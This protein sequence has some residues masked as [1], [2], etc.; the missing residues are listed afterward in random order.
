MNSSNFLALNTATKT[1]LKIWR[2]R[3]RCTINRMK[4]IGRLLNTSKTIFEGQR[5]KI[6]G[7]GISMRIRLELCRGRLLRFRA[8]TREF[9][10][11]PRVR[12]KCT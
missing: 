11:R 1:V 6:K 8:T 10:G 7:S 2:N 9:A 4:N 3:W 5:L 12:R